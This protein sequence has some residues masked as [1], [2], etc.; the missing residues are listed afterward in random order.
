VRIKHEGGIVSIYG[1][2]SRINDGIVTGRTV[3]VGEMIG[4]VGSSGL[5]TGPHLHYG[6]EKDGQYVNP[7]DQHLGVHHQ[8]SPRLRQVF[9][10]F[11]GEYL[12]AL[13]RLPLGGHYA[14]SLTGT[15]AA[16]NA[17]MS[18]SSNPGS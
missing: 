18:E 4:Q 13:N 3:R 16:G 8:V 2:L 10:R 1:H 14:V 15:Q 12:E 17:V 7:L 11:K 5:S 9:D 6:I